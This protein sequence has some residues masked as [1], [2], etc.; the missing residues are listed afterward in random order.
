[1]ARPLDDITRV[2]LAADGTINAFFGDASFAEDGSNGRVM[3]RIPRCYVKATNPSAS[4]YKWFLSDQPLSG[5]ELHPAFYQRGGT[6]KKF[7]YIASYEADLVPDAGGSHTLHSRSGKQPMTGGVIYEVPFDAG[8]NEPDVDDVLDSDNGDDG[9]TL[10]GYEVTSGA[11]GDNDAAGKLW[12]RKVGD[13]DPGWS[14]DDTITNST[15]GDE[16]VCTQNGADSAIDFDIDD[17]ED[18][19]NNIGSGWGVTNIWTRQL[20][21]L[22]MMMDWG[23]LDSQSTVGRGIVD[24]ASG[25]G[26]AGELTASNS[27]NSNLD[28]DGTISSSYGGYA[29]EANDGTYPIA[30]RYIENFWGNVWE[31]VIGI[32]ALDAEYRVLPKAGLA[33]ATCD[34]T[35]GAGDYTASTCTPLTDDDG[36]IDDIE[37]ET[38]LEYLF[39]PSS[40]GGGAATYIPDYFYSHDSGETNVWLAG[41]FWLQGSWAGA[42]SSA[43]HQA[44]SISSRFIG[45]RLEYL[46][47]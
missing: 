37:W 39:I 9:W 38:L 21:L 17:A 47:Q 36:Y 19:A 28:S 5:Y 4:V 18:F 15:Q 31:F 42:G 22:L 41:G 35:L 24:K 27:I 11:W 8:N 1:M 13:D 20:V 14:D 3:V 34:G 29:G 25:T 2:N 26:F 7:I 40:S 45:S 23:D 32:N 10:V 46:P 44:A 16:T 6:A 33:A 30:W 12:I 43:E